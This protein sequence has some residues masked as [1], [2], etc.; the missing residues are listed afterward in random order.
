MGST[1]WGGGEGGRSGDAM[2]K[3]WGE[4][5]SEGDAARRHH[6]NGGGG[7]AA[8]PNQVR[9]RGGWVWVEGGGWGGSGGL[10]ECVAH[11]PPTGWRPVGTHVPLT[12]A[13]TATR[14]EGPP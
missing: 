9:R 7:L 13:N 5:P 3:S 1:H 6:S 8:R 10:R 4:V 12:L 2:P 11:D 14:R